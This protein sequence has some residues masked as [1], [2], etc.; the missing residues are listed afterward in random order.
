MKVG[1]SILAFK[2]NLVCVNVEI[3][4]SAS[5]VLLTNANP[6]ISCVIPD[7]FPVK[8]ASIA[9]TLDT[10]TAPEVK[11]ISLPTSLH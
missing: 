7:T 5:L 9:C 11:D 3:G 4:L 10:I 8:V 2:S 6:I 1:L